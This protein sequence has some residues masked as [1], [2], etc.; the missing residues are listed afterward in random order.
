MNTFFKDA[1]YVPEA[2]MRLISNGRLA[3]GVLDMTFALDDCTIRNTNRKFMAEGICSS[4]DL[5]YITGEP[6]VSSNSAYIIMAIPNL[7]GLA[8]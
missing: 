6:A 2:S 1:L 4:T 3:D 7:I 8:L 5:Y